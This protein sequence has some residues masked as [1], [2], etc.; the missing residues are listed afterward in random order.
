MGFKI[1]IFPRFPLIVPH[2]IKWHASFYFFYFFNLPWQSSE[3]VPLLPQAQEQVSNENILL[4]T[5][6][7]D[8]AIDHPHTHVVKCC[9]MVKGEKRNISFLLLFLFPHL[10]LN[11]IEK[12]VSTVLPITIVIFINTSVAEPKLFIL[13]SDSG[14]TFVHNFGS[15][16]SSCHILPLKTAL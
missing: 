16:S 13:D 9:Q 12:E 3:T 6:G 5:L 8:V 1:I 10:E 7:F 15:S 4:Q 14:S 2:Q 11:L